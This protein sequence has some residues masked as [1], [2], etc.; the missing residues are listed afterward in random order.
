MR[1]L[2]TLLL[3][4]V[5]RSRDPD[6]WWGGPGYGVPATH[7]EV[8]GMEC[9]HSSVA[10]DLRF[11]PDEV[12]FE[13]RQIRDRCKSVP[14]SYQP[15]SFICKVGACTHDDTQASV[16]AWCSHPVPA[17]AG[18]FY[19]SRVVFIFFSVTHAIQIKPAVHRL[20]KEV[21]AAGSTAGSSLAFSCFLRLASAP[22]LAYPKSCPPSRAGS[23]IFLSLSQSLVTRPS[24]RVLVMIPRAVQGHVH[25][26]QLSLVVDLK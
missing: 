19:V 15:P 20:M 1:T 13:G 14:S 23:N 5:C 16:R 9:E 26:T 22:G 10:L 2:L 24:L 3:I 11:I 4:A 6:G 8:D 17:S 7:R 21:P 12:S 18:G 25:A